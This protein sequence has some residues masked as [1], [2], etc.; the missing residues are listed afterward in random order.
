M[1]YLGKKGGGYENNIYY[2]NCT[3]IWGDIPNIHLLDDSWSKLF[4]VLNKPPA[5]TIWL[6]TLESTHWLLVK[7]QNN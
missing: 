6:S 7:K 2:E 3:V 1:Y 5:P 4:K